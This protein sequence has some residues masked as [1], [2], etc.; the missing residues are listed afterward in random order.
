MYLIERVGVN[1]QLLSNELTKLA[2]YGPNITKESIDLL[3][4]PTPQ[5]TVFQL[6]DAAFA[7]D[8]KKTL[9]IYQEQRAGKLEPQALIAMLTWQFHVVAVVKAAGKRSDADIA[10]ETKISPF[11]IRKSKQI[12]NNLTTSRLKLLLSQLL[13]LDIKTKT[14]TLDADDA[15]QAFL[16][17]IAC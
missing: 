16:L 15:L 1:Q 5:S 2:A 11:V 8:G 13:Q 4:E 9:A 12:S 14:T 3:T 6:L 10:A 17:H 7:G